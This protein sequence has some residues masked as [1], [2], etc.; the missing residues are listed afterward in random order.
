MKDENVTPAHNRLHY[1]IY[2]HAYITHDNLRI[3]LMHKRCINMRL[4]IFPDIVEEIYTHADAY[5]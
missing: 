4:C 1:T 5:I 2:M 3:Y